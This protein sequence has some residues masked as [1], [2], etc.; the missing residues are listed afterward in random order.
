MKI[1]K[2][3]YWVGDEDDKHWMDLYFDVSK[4]TAFCIPTQDI[5]EDGE[6]INIFFDGEMI[7]IKQEE[8]IMKYLLDKFVI[9]AI[10]L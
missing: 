8:H 2:L 6:A 7:T 10:E 3:K 5:E 4:I 9:K 1:Y